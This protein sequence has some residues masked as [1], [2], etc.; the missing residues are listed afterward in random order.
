MSDMYKGL[1]HPQIII[2][3]HHLLTLMSFQTVWLTFFCGI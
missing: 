1:V 2:F 3:F